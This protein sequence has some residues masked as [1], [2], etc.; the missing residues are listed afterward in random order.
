[1]VITQVLLG[2][3]TGPNLELSVEK[4]AGE[5]KRKAAAAAAAAAVVVFL[6]LQFSL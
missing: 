4:Y 3:P 5:P 6:K 2:R 1:M